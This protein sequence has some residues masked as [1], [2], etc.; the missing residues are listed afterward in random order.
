MERLHREI[1]DLRAQ[2]ASARAEAVVAQTPAAP[3]AA[4]V[5]E[6]TAD[7]YAG[8]RPVAAAPLRTSRRTRVAS[9][10]DVPV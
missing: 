6:P 4:P 3:E 10:K 2:L 1:E 8:Q 7:S 9:V 5:A